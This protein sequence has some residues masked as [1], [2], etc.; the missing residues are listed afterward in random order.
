MGENLDS[1]VGRVEREAAT[2]AESVR[3]LQEAVRTIPAL[4]QQVAVIAS[5][6]TDVRDDIASLRSSLT[7][8]DKD[9]AQ[10]RRSLR[11]A[12]IGL[13]GVILAAIIGLVATIIA[14]RGGA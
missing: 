11:N 6:M 2:L 1:R 13:V 10:D 7:E 4:A 14:S 12:V 9:A 3:G 5:G 8:R